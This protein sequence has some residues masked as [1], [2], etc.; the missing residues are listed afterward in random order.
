[1]SVPNSMTPRSSDLRVLAIASGKG[2]VGKTMLSSNLAWALGSMDKKVLIVDADLGLANVDIVLGLAPAYHIGHL[3]SGQRSLDEVLVTAAPNVMVLPAASGIAELAEMS[4]AHKLAFLSV[5]DELERRFDF[6]IIDNA[7]GIGKN[8]IYFTGA[9]QEVLIVITLEPTSITDA[10]AAIKILSQNA[11]ITRFDLVV[12]MVA[13]LQEA[14]DVFARLTTVASRFLDVQIRLLGS[15]QRDQSTS[16]AVLAQ[17]PLLS[18]FPQ[19]PASRCVRR[20]AET[21]AARTPEHLVGRS[22]VTHPRMPGVA[23]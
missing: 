10:Y 2:G 20:I 13:S 3:L 5:L 14:E 8:V 19:S 6:I 17:Q 23:L 1:M 4:D 21:L 12:N 7:A 16:R 9:G 11:G 15:I 22:S 18:L